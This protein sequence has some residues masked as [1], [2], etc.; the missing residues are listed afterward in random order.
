MWPFNKKNE[1]L[2]DIMRVQT[3]PA[4]LP[5]ISE[6]MKH[7]DRE[8]LALCLSGGGSF[9]RWEAGFI[10]YLDQIGVLPLIN[11]VAGTSVGAINGT[12]LAVTMTAQPLVDLW[13]GIKTSADVYGGDMI[14]SVLTGGLWRA[15]LLDPRPLYKII[16]DAVSGKKLRVPMFTIASDFQT[17]KMVILDAKNEPVDQA[18]ASSAVPG[19]FPAWKIG[20]RYYLD[21][22]LIQNIPIPFLLTS[23]NATKVIVLY[24]SPENKIEPAPLSKAPNAKD[25]GIAIVETA[26]DAQEEYTDVIIEQTE[27][28]RDALG[29][30]PVEFAR[31]WPRE[32][33]GDNFLNFG[34]V[35]AL[36]QGYDDACRYLTPTKLAE[37]LKA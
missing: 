5:V 9:G 14:F 1:M 3:D 37:L 8:V 31:F 13:R 30:P 35:Q 19:A 33:A 23:C 36:Q 18:L 17:Q 7:M 11:I 10:A 29:E 2:P 25:T 27:K 26:M 22:G 6:Y 32:K 4:F 34:N 12:K 20:D 21:G 24:C 28:L 15:G 16:Q